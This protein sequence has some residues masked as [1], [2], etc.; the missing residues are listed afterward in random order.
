MSG[1]KRPQEVAAALQE[2]ELRMNVHFLYGVR[3]FGRYEHEIIL[4]DVV[5]IAGETINPLQ[6]QPVAA[7]GPSLA[8]SMSRTGNSAL[9]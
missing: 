2:I 3:G 1:T 6:V 4:V 5:A 8:A 9:S 7:L